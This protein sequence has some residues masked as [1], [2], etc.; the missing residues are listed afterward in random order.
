MLHIGR[1]L[2]A[3]FP[4]GLASATLLF[5]SLIGP[6]TI[7]SAWADARPQVVVVEKV[8]DFGT[9][10][11]GTVVKHDFTIRN[12]GD[13]DLV[14]Q[15]VIPACGCT[16][17]TA[18]SEP[19]VP[20][21]ERAV[22]VSFDT[23]GFS[24][25]KY[26]TVRVNTN[27]VDNL[28]VVL[29]LR[30]VVEPDVVVEPQSVMFEEVIRGSSEPAEEQ[31]VT[32]SLKEGAKVKVTGA[33]AFSPHVTVKELERSAARAKFSVSIDPSA[34]LGELRDRMVIGVDGGKESTINVPIFAVVR[35]QLALQPPQL[36]FG[37]IEGSELITRSVKLVNRGASPVRV[38]EVRSANPAISTSVREI[39][40]GK[41]F[42]VQVQLNPAQV[43][44]DLRASVE[45][46]TDSPDE[47]S[48][49]LSIFGI[50]PP[51][52]T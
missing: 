30:G 44:R 13:S 14:I 22:Q 45:V 43:K 6:E 10:S 18:S 25:E 1:S 8:F 29:A 37:V 52:S 39:E 24:G 23:A 9:V 28:S 40:A 5:V 16:A 36:S 50:L 11:Q 38:K 51:P 4:S 7:S 20:G 35:G 2:S 46:L 33:R 49:S 32:I 21:A 31:V 12:G 27:D 19:I 34:P 42:V 47:P 15:R 26:K 41:T 3:V 48:L 17:A